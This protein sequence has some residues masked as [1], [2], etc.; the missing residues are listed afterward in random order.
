MAE[1][2]VKFFFYNN[3]YILVIEHTVCI[4]SREWDKINFV[5]QGKKGRGNNSVSHEIYNQNPNFGS[6]FRNNQN[7]PK[8]NMSHTLL[9]HPL[10]L[11]TLKLVY[12]NIYERES[13]F[14]DLLWLVKS[15][16]GLLL[17]FLEYDQ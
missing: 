12:N 11:P 5:G 8:A 9:L 3:E 14:K 17:G 10:S 7:N 1:V 15:R 2:K 4:P 16:T 6:S 13:F